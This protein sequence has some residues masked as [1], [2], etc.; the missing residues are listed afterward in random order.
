M[1]K[2]LHMRKGLSNTNFPMKPGELAKR[3]A[4]SLATVRGKTSQNKFARQLGISNASL[5]RIENQQQNVSL[6]TLEMICTKLKCDIAD[7]FP[8]DK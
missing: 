2:S 6:E 3:L 7:L 4:K 1:R 8:P 5:N